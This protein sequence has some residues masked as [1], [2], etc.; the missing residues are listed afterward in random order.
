MN[1]VISKLKNIHP[2]KILTAFLASIFLLVTQACGSVAATAPNPTVGSQSA[3]PN[4]QIY[5]PKGKNVNSPY[6]GGMNNFSDTDPRTKSAE[7]KAEALKDNA[8]RNLTNRT[9]NPAESIRRVL[10]DK[11]ELGKN[12]QQGAGN[13]KQKA[14]ETSEDF[15][16]GTRE[17]I[18]NIKENVKDSTRDLSTNIQRSAE[19]T[20][21][22]AQR[23]AEDT[24]YAVNKTVKEAGGNVK[25]GAQETSENLAQ[26]GQNVIDNAKNFIQDSTNQAVKSV[27]NNLDKASATINNTVND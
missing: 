12:I 7:T 17:G 5:V 14:Q 8:E 23:T 24:G 11:N 16:R 18:N 13:I 9:G 4:S 6:E 2:F 25:Y 27:K 15:G 20:K 26:K 19:D 10:E 22:N 21:L 3:E 1:V